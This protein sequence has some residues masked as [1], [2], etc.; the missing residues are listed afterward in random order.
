MCEEMTLSPLSG[1]AGVK[2]IV[3]ITRKYLVRYSGAG[4]FLSNIGHLG[5]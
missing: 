5:T 4:N 1:L 3:S 2:R